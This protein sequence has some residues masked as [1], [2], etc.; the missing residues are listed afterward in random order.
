MKS[1]QD[2][3]L[4][5]FVLDNWK[6]EAYTIG[7]ILALAALCYYFRER[8]RSTFGVTECLR[9]Q[10]PQEEIVGGHTFQVCVWRVDIKNESEQ[11]EEMTHTT[12]MASLPGSA[13]RTM[14]GE[15][16]FWGWFKR[17]S[18]PDQIWVR[19]CYG[20]EEVQRTR[21]QRL[22]WSEDSYVYRF[23]EIFTLSLEQRRGAQFKVELRGNNFL[24]DVTFDVDR[25][26]RAFERSN[27]AAQG[28]RLGRSVADEQIF[29]MR[30]PPLSAL[31]E[32]E[33]NQRMR[34]VGF[35]PFAGNNGLQVWLAFC[36]VDEFDES[37]PR[38]L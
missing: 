19:L 4:V 8:I 30:R 34:E 36:N 38:C 33:T 9:V 10:I 5:T 20:N 1:S 23:Q 29:R 26:N 6:Y 14:T 18:M 32:A 35:H 12:M 31:Q 13:W 21:V 27:W 2:I 11:I 3:E 24:S 37:I 22:S 15:T 16:S 25:L 17:P 28:L 7:V